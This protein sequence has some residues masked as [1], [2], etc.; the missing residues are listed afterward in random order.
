MNNH[1]QRLLSR[2][3][4]GTGT[5]VLLAA[6]TS[7]HAEESIRF[8]VVKDDATERHI[9]IV[10]ETGYT[11]NGVLKNSH[12]PNSIVYQHARMLERLRRESREISAA[13]E[14]ADAD[15]AVIDPLAGTPVEEKKPDP[16]FS[17]GRERKTVLEELIE[18]EKRSG[19]AL[20]PAD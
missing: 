13:E 5:V 18:L 7:V 6:V 1:E 11:E 10:P 12:N 19:R 16:V 17:A 8:N 4:R 9:S 15:P 14:I 20:P 2:L 3:I